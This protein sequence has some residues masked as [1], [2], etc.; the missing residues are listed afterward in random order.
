MPGDNLDKFDHLVVLMMENRSF[1]CL[2]GYLYEHDAPARFLGRGDPVFRGIPEAGPLW[3]LDDSGQRIPVAKAPWAT[4]QDMCNPTPDP[5]EE[6]APHINRQVYGIDDA[7]TDISLLPDTAPMSGFVQDYTRAIRAQVPVDSMLPTPDHYRI[8]M[9]CFPPEAMPVMNGLARA[10]ACSDEWFCSVPS[11]TFCNRSFLHSAQSH[12]NVTN[13]N[14]VKWRHNDAPT[15]FDRLAAKFG[16]AGAWR[17]YW[18]HAD[19]LPLTRFIHHALGDS[20]YDANFRDF[21]AF[22]ADCASGD[23]PRYT[24]IQPRLLFNHNDMHPPIFL[25]PF[26]DSSLLAGELL[27]NDV[28]NAVRAGRKWPRTLLVILFDEHGGTYDHWPPPKGAAP[29]VA[30]PDYELEAGFRFDRFGV[31]VPAIFVSPYV[32]AGTVVR[33]PGETPFDHT[34]IVKTACLRWGLDSLTARDA[35]APDIVAALSLPAD[36]P[37]LDT[38]AFTPRPYEPIPESDAHAGLLSS[39]QKDLLGLAAH[40]LGWALPALE[41]FGEALGFLRGGG[42]KS[43]AS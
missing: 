10:F 17:I 30:N 25:N 34:S 7:P 8:I 24:F 31:R 12:G 19:H 16:A 21:A 18:D 35:A 15:L 40:K 23:L 33:A 29:P 38:P 11:Q 6:Y 42:G 41:R 9:N 3:N 20:A 43:A 2:L 14:Y 1:D 39:M 4:P 26:V 28:Y 13:S 37:R 32:E 27:I 22:A 5:G 36:R